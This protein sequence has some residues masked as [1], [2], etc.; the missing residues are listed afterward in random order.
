MT[1]VSRPQALVVGVLAAVLTLAVVLRSTP[2]QA[3]ATHVD[4][5]LVAEPPVSYYGIATIT[6]GSVDCATRKNTIR[7]AIVLTRDGT[8]AA[9]GDR[10]C[11]KASTCWSYL[12]A[13][14][15]PG[16]QLWCTRVSARIGSHSLGEVTRCEDTTL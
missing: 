16:D 4:C 14:D 13:D 2:G 6:S 8:V 12:F 11:H 1:T 15:P 3:L 10:T 7:F 5:T 9:S